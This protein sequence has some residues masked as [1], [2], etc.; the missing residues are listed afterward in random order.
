M[1]PGFE[2]VF[3]NLEREK[4]VKMARKRFTPEQITGMLIEAEVRLSQGETP[5]R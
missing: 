3:S 2:L 5:N 4:E 1:S